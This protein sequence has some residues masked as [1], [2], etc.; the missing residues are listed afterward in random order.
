MAMPNKPWF[1]A[2][3]GTWY[4]TL[5]GK[6]VSLGVRGRRNSKAA[7]EAWHRLMAEGKKEAPRPPRDP[8]VSEVIALYLADC[9]GRLKPKTLY[10]YKSFL[11]P[12]RRRHGGMLTTDLTPTLAES[13]ARK[14]HWSDTT[15][16]D[17]LGTLAGVFRWAERARVI[18][19]TPLL[20]LRRPPR[21]SRG[22][23]VLLTAGEREALSAAATLQF[24]VV[25]EVLWQTGMRP[26]EAAAITA[27]NFDTDAGLVRL[28]DHK[29]AHK[30]KARVI[31]LPPT[32]VEVLNRLKG[33]YPS[34]PLLRN[35]CGRLWTG[36][37]I[38]KAMQATRGR[39]GLAG[40][41]AYGL[42]HTFAT[43][44]LAA[45][46]P[47]AQVAELLGHSGTAMLH[48][49]Y[50]HLVAKARVLREALDRVRREA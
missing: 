23:E 8:T 14:P 20:G 19:R 11:D 27:E 44:A 43:D 1:R 32:V 38:V 16:H 9:E 42:R 34:G 10:D 4:C 40:K 2:S 21:A 35:R 5:S 48:K 31:Y 13:Y 25:L 37:A 50:S 26:G 6:K 3:K 12:F 39:A 46:V 33:L 45:G 22:L 30:G 47:D 7:R 18:A 28:K 17:F 41:V 29:T 15:R 24:R 49:H 36:W